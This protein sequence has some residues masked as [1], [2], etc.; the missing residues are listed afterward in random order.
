MLDKLPADVAE[1]P[2]SQ[3]AREREIKSDAVKVID[4]PNFK[5][6]IPKTE[7]ASC[8]YGSGT[9]WCTAARDNNV[10]DQYNKQG[11]LYIIMA[12][13]GGR[14]RKFQLHVEGDQ[15]MDERDQSVNKRDIAALSNMP[16]YTKFLNQLIEKHY[17]KYFKNAEA[18][19]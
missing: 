15:F 7:E 13:L 12:N 10:F 18:A 6:I 2:Q 11:N 19:T 4:T 17:G 5:V 1:P 9:R 16:E 3:R 8:L 14:Q